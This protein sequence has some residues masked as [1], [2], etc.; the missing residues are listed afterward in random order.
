M[1]ERISSA[2]TLGLGSAGELP[3][4]PA[5]INLDP[6]HGIVQG[7]A[8]VALGMT[9]IFSGPAAMHLMWVLWDSRFRGFTRLE[10][11]LVA[12]CGF[13]GC[14]II[15]ISAVFGLIFGITA[16]LAARGIIALRRSAWPAS[17]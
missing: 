10:I 8:S 1:D 16:I 6:W 15:L 2:D 3:A 7:L 12:I 11:V 5:R 9:F 4:E 17:C 14:L 13:L